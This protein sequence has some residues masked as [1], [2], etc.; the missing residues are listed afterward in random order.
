MCSYI[1]Q[2]T[3]KNKVSPGLLAIAL[4]IVFAR[5]LVELY[6]FIVTSDIFMDE[7][8][9]IQAALRMFTHG[10]YVWD[11]S[12]LRESFFEPTLSIGLAASWFS[13][14]NWG[15]FGNLVAT[16]LGF[17][18]FCFALFCLTM[19]LVPTQIT[20]RKLGPL[21]MILIWV[22]FFRFVPYSPAAVSQSLG[23]FPGAMLILLGVIFLNNGNKKWRVLGPI[24]LG[25]SVWHAKLIFLPYA[26]LA[27]FSFQKENPL[28]SRT[29]ARN[30]IKECGLF[31]TPLLAW[32]LLIGLVNTP[33]Q[34]GQ[35]LLGKFEFINVVLSGYEYRAVAVSVNIFDRLGSPEFEWFHYGLRWKLEIL[36]LIFVPAFLCAGFVLKQW[37]KNRNLPVYRFAFP[38]G[39]ALLQCIFAV[40]YF[41]FHFKMWVRH[42]QPTMLM[43]FFLLVASAYYYL[44]TRR[45]KPYKDRVAMAIVMALFIIPL[46]KRGTDYF[47]APVQVNAKLAGC[48]SAEPWKFGPMDLDVC[49]K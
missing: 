35:W 3:M 33:T 7:L 14:L 24:F 9:S 2:N 19:R 45:I 47:N 38:V 6:S 20:E 17:F 39:F 23:E 34:V 30:L 46:I 5:T 21:S 12:K 1:D 40:W 25:L 37:R 31:L 10:H 16:R 11:A 28:S 26:L 15:I 32:L 8:N 27:L 44:T 13:G 49:M 43:G 41:G 29:A 42:I 48:R 22:L 4:G 18:V 36:F